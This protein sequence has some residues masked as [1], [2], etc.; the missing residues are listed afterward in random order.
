[1]K[2]NLPVTMLCLVTTLGGCASGLPL[3]Q[4]PSDR[5]NIIMTDVSTA[6]TIT[7]PREL[8]VVTC[9]R[10]NADVAV[11]RT[12]SISLSTLNFGNE[13]DTNGEQETELQGRTPG[14]LAMR[15][16]LYHSCLLYQSG[17]ISAPDLLSMTH[18]ILGRSYDIL[19]T[20]ADNSQWVFNEQ[21]AFSESNAMSDQTTQ[22]TVPQA[23]SNSSSAS[24]SSPPMS[25]MSSTDDSS[26]DDFADFD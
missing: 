17:A 4:V 5:N 20:E 15:D 6:M 8:G 25:A 24:T 13:G 22:M 23:T 19:Q 9:S 3:R 14:V 7:R 12:S 10:M 2:H 11:S 18:T 1:M 26:D 16:A 21:A